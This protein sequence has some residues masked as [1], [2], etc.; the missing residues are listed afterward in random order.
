LTSDF[1]AGLFQDLRK[2]VPDLVP[3]FRLN[4]K[5]KSWVVNL[6]SEDRKL[7]IEACSR[8]VKRTGRDK[9]SIQHTEKFYSMLL[10]LIDI[11][12][13]NP[14]VIPVMIWSNLVPAGSRDL[15]LA[16]KWG[17]YV[18]SSRD[19]RLEDVWK[20]SPEAVNQNTLSH[21]I[22]RISDAE[23]KPRWHWI[24]SEQKLLIE[25]ILKDRASTTNR[26]VEDLGLEPNSSNRIKVVGIVHDLIKEGKAR[27]LLVGHVTGEGIVCGTDESQLEK[28]EGS[29]FEK[30][31]AEKRRARLS[32]YALTVL[33]DKRG[34]NAK[35]VAEALNRRWHIQA[36]ISEMGGLLGRR[37]SKEGKIHADRSSHVTRYF[38]RE[39]WEK[40]R[41]S[42]AMS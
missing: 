32:H 26:L 17:V 27:K 31:H 25:Q 19:L 24:H 34:L 28:I 8:T 12:G 16:S 36:T 15:Q 13:G 41:A 21:L 39:W 2:K 37:L 3:E 14:D 11:K 23:L 33:T 35:E 6:Y 10:K 5:G 22:R 40:N 4:G 29:L 18:L 30:Y 20:A 42:E 38:L 1:E 7:V 9:S